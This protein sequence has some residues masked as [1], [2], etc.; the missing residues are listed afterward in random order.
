MWARTSVPVPLTA[1]PTQLAPSSLHRL[2]AHAAAIAGQTAEGE[3]PPVDLVARS[4]V[5]EKKGP[6]EASLMP[7]PSGGQALDV[8]WVPVVIWATSPVTK[9]LYFMTQQ[10][11]V[12]SV[13]FSRK[14]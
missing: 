5:N 13:D 9:S 10:L 14:S 6:A 12:T 3:A 11:Q 8:D 4:R 1:L 7:S 2:A